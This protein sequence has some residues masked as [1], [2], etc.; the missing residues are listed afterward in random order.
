MNMKKIRNKEIKN[1]SVVKQN[2]KSDWKMKVV[3]LK[4]NG[5]LIN[6]N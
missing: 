4:K 2:G 1:K 3:D 6:C 5:C